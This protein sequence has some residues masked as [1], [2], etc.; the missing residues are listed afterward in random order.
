MLHAGVTKKTIAKALD[1]MRTDRVLPYRFIA[2]AKHAPELE[3][4]LEHAMFR[5]IEGHV[6]LKGK[7]R[8]LAAPNGTG[9]FV[10]HVEQVVPGDLSKTPGLLEAT[11]SQL[12]QG[13]SEEYGAQ[14]ARAVERSLN[15]ERNQ[16]ATA[17]SK[18]QLQ[19]GG[20]T[21]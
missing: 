18:R 17:R 6:R 2:A 7:T 15:I 8:L 11:R 9:W 21:E 12:S 19:T 13:A 14:F 16:A 10:V 20:A 5:S 1:A 4:E 3:P